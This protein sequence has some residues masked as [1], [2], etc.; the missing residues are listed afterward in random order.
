MQVAPRDAVARAGVRGMSYRQPREIPQDIRE[1]ADAALALCS[2]LLG[3]NDVAALEHNV[4]SRRLAAH[5]TRRMTGASF[6]TLGHLFRKDNSTIQ[7]GERAMQEAIR[8]PDIAAAVDAMVDALN[9]EPLNEAIITPAR[10]ALL[11]NRSSVGFDAEAPSPACLR[12]FGCQRA[13]CASDAQ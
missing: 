9:G 2:R 1:V 13:R 4:E 6:P 11:G 8:R 12:R 10:R 3:E 7:A 5:I